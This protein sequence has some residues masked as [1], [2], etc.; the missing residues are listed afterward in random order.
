MSRATIDCK[1]SFRDTI[2]AVHK[3]DTARITMSSSLIDVR[4]FALG[5]SGSSVSVSLVLSFLYSLMPGLSATGA[6]SLLLDPTFEA[7]TDGDWDSSVCGICGIC[8][9][10][11]CDDR[12]CN[13]CT[14][15]TVGTVNSCCQAEIPLWITC[16]V[17]LIFLKV[18]WPAPRWY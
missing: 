10:L 7:L 1:F 16:N 17:C 15:V 9:L 12:N 13:N 6:L 8:P 14:P 3:T 11:E 18:V 2:L 4:L 5:L